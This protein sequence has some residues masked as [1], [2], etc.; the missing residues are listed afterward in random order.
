MELL[1]EVAPR[2]ADLVSALPGSG[3]KGFQR[4]AKSR[5]VTAEGG[6]NDRVHRCVL[7]HLG[8]VSGL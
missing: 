3:G 2:S 1:G 4:I 6:M 8:P 5:D 7:S